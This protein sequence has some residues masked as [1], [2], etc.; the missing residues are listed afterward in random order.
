VFGKKVLQRRLQHRCRQPAPAKRGIEV[1]AHLCYLALGIQIEAAHTHSPDGQPLGDLCNADVAFATFQ[2]IDEPSLVIGPSDFSLGNGGE[3]RQRIITPFEEV[4][5]VLGRCRPNIDHQSTMLL[6]ILVKVILFSPFSNI[7]EHSFPEALVAEGLIER[8]A[9]VLAVRCNGMLV[10]HCVAMSAAGVTAES[11]LKVR[12]QV[13]TACIKRRNLL[14]EAMPFDSVILDE[15]VRAEDREQAAAARAAVSLENWTEFDLEGVPLGRHA[16]YEFLLDNKILGTDIPDRLWSQYLNKLDQAVL[17]F[18]AGRRLLESERPDRVLVYN[19]LYAV[20]HAFCEAAKT[21]G[22]PSYTLQGGGHVVRRGETMTMFRDTQSLD[23]VF[24]SEAWA[25]YRSQPV[26]ASEVS[27]VSEHFA[28]LLEANSA[29]AYSSAFEASQPA[30]LRKRFDIPAGAPVLLVP[31]SSEDEINAARL[32]DVLPA[33]SNVSS[34]FPDQFAWIAFLFEFAKARPELQLI[35]RLHP[36]MFPNKRENVLSPVVAKLMTLLDSRP[37]NVSLNLPTDAVSMYDLMQ[38]VDVLLNFRSSAG[39]ELSAFGIPVVVPANRDFFTYPTELNLTGTTEDD[40][41]SKIDQALQAGWSIDQTRMAF[42]WFAFLFSRVAVDLSKSV[43]SRPLAIRPKK[44]GFRLWAWR[45]MVWIVL[46]Y[47]PLVRERVALR[48]RSIEPGS[49][50][51]FYDVLKQGR[52]SLAESSMWPALSATESSETAE[53]KQFLSKLCDNEWK[54]VL[55]ADSLAGRIRSF[56][57][58]ARQ[59]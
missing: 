35:I 57:G 2:A 38:I 42:R 21:L 8:G 56:L 5:G 12:Q 13:C 9:S 32:A 44:P 52:G 27:L 6:S 34:L 14:D 36:R 3:P 11:P 18:L 4:S 26:G 47:G 30:E 37:A 41:A 50:D 20:N 23:E 24:R 53:L 49:R 17:T 19:R 58:G 25:S 1:D 48:N 43:H 46:Q 28:G 55:D 54:S 16:A 15:L 22:I 10:S 40:Y 33:T 31:L 39:A 59:E 29:F 45:K 51:I 7:W